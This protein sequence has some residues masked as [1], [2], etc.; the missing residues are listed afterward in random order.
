[1]CSWTTSLLNDAASGPITSCGQIHLP[2]TALFSCTPM[3]SDCAVCSKGYGRGVGYTCHSCDNSRSQRLIW[4]GVMAFGVVLLLLTILGVLFLVGGLDAVDTVRKSVRRSMSMKNNSIS[5]VWSVSKTNLQELRDRP[6]RRAKEGFSTHTFASAYDVTRES[7]HGAGER[8]IGHRSRESP[9]ASPGPDDAGGIYVRPSVRPGVRFA[10]SNV[11]TKHAR[12]DTETPAGPRVR[13]G[14]NNERKPNGCGLGAKIKA[15][16]SRLPLHKLKILVVVW[17]ILTVFVSITDVEFPES[18]SRLLAWMDV[19]SFNMGHIF[20]ASCI[21]PSV[22]F[23]TSLLVTTLTPLALVAVLLLTYQMA[24]RRAGTGPAGVLARRAAWSR[25]VGAGLLLTYLVSFG[26]RR[27]SFGKNR[28]AFIVSQVILACCKFY[29]Y[30]TYNL[31]ISD[32]A[33]DVSAIRMSLST[34]KETGHTLEYI[35]ARSLQCVGGSDT[36]TYVRKP[37]T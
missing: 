26:N 20:S 32:W 10:V 22:N 19:V 31:L 30:V 23:Y 15:W 14:T 2:L 27:F 1:M 36:S 9:P 8:D 24:K 6:E 7:R 29:V 3:I 37:T 33:V 4:A 25:H 12:T 17:Q 18:Y 11:P 21:L 16:T 28:A 13:L 34:G 35:C 5:R